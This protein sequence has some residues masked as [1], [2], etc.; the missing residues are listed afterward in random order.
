MKSFS[1]YDS[2]HPEIYELYKQI[3]FGLIKRGATKL[4]S[5]RIIEEIR[6]H[7]FVKTNEPIKVGN[8]YTCWYARKFALDYPQFARMFEFKALRKDI[9]FVN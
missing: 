6:W 8:N 2:E 3:A 9:A 5:K 1:Q 4:G 7:H